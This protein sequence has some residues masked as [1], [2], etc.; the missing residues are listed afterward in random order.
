MASSV[1]SLIARSEK[2]IRDYRNK[3]RGPCSFKEM[4]VSGRVY[5]KYS[6]EEVLRTWGRF[7]DTVCHSVVE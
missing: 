1:S 6:K 3:M 5:R 4:A 2:V 7:G